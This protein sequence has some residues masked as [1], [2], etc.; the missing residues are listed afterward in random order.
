MLAQAN[1]YSGATEIV[2]ATVDVRDPGRPR[3][4][5]RHRVDPAPVVTLSAEKTGS[6]RLSFNGVLSNPI[7]F[8]ATAS[9]V[10][11]VLNG[12]SSIGGAGGSVTV[13]R[14]NVE[15]TTQ[16]GPVWPDTGFVYTI[17]FGGTLANTVVALTAN[18][19]NGTGFRRAWRPPAASTCELATAQ[20]SNWTRPAPRHPAASR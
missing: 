19:Q 10:Q 13:T 16:N 4:S 3:A 8:G 18:G 2:E 1:T 7:N 14:N 12:L 15:T 11:T 9:Q 6:F 17:T 20:R 5:L